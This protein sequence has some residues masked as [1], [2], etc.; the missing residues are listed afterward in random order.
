M[1]RRIV[2]ILSV[3]LLVL[4]AAG[5][6]AP[7]EA[8]RATP[9]AIPAEAQSAE[10]VVVVLT[11]TPYPTETVE[12]PAEESAEDPV[13]EPVAPVEPQPVTFTTT[14]GLTLHGTLYGGGSKGVVLAHM[15]P[16]DQTSWAPFAEKLAEAGY[17]AL[18]FDFR[19]YG[20]S[21]EGAIADIPLDTDAALAFLQEQGAEQVVLVGAS[22]GGTASVNTAAAFPSGVD[23]LV[24]IASPRDFQGMDVTI[25]ELDNLLMPSLWVAAE[26]DGAATPTFE[27]AAGA[28]GE[29]E[30][31]RYPGRSEHGTFL[32][33]T[34]VGPDLEA[35]LL[36]FIEAALE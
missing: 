24:V 9:T 14:D 7:Q 18:T 22:M 6:D 35:A 36:A 31:I 34:E 26:N 33:D 29:V 20:E 8:A 23:G 3:L 10:Q 1:T 17:M 15:F 28:P 19:G 11:A 5:C 30:E 27:M 25:S 13:E 12:A 4:S 16:T 32:F 2:L 21:D